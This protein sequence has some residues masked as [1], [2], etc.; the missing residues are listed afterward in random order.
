MEANILYFTFLIF[1]LKHVFKYFLY[2]N[3]YQLKNTLLVMQKI[4]QKDHIK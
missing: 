2:F 3:L 1:E 4:M